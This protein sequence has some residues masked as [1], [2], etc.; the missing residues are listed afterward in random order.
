[1]ESLWIEKISEAIS[2]IDKKDKVKTIVPM[3]E[4]LSLGEKQVESILKLLKVSEN[5][6]GLEVLS[7][8]D[9]IQNELL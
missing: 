9:K 8:F 7:F 5:Q 2:I 1:L 3:L 6:R 4:E